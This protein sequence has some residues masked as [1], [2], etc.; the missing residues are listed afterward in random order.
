MKV[1]NLNQLEGCAVPKLSE[2]EP[3]QASAQHEQSLWMMAEP[4]GKSSPSQESVN[5]LWPC[6]ENPQIST[7]GTSKR[8]QIDSKPAWDSGD[9]RAA[10]HVLLSIWGFPQSSQMDLKLLGEVPKFQTVNIVLNGKSGYVTQS[11]L[12]ESRRPHHKTRISA[13]DEMLVFSY[14]SP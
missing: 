13:T 1:T 2:L 12:A 3:F 14:S 7:A 5:S 10:K 6:Q 11:I 9:S 8:N 4:A